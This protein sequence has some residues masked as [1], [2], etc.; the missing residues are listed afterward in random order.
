MGRV[1]LT[2]KSIE[3]IKV[4]ETARTQKVSGG[5]SVTVANEGGSAKLRNGSG[6]AIYPTSS[7]AKKAVRRHNSQIKFEKI[8]VLP[9][10]S[11]RR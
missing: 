9:S 11:M 1:R 7:A 10:L 3:N 6:V 2:E 8:K 4:A 5:Y